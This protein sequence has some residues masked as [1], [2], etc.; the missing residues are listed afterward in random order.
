MGAGDCGAHA[1]RA[2]ARKRAGRGE[3]SAWTCRGYG[4]STVRETRACRKL[5]MQEKSNTP[6]STHAHTRI[7]VIVV[8]V[9]VLLV[10]AGISRREETRYSWVEWNAW[11]HSKTSGI[12]AGNV[13]EH[14]GVLHT[15]QWHTF[16]APLAWSRS[17]R[18]LHQRRHAQNDNNNGRL[19]RYAISTCRHSC[20]CPTAGRGLGLLHMQPGKA[21][22]CIGV[23]QR[24]RD[25]RGN[26]NSFVQKNLNDMQTNWKLQKL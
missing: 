23:Q 5:S 10:V 22:I 11:R 15:V 18:M 25:R 3:R 13:E 9:V 8:V 24:R 6:P 12:N 7:T 17:S 4:L 1:S 21:H 19:Q 16:G 2:D 14:T 20:K 26:K